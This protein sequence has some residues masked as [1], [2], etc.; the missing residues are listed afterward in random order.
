MI[1]LSSK[2]DSVSATLVRTSYLADVMSRRFLTVQNIKKYPLQNMGKIRT[3]IR[4]RNH[5]KIFIDN[6]KKAQ[7]TLYI[8]IFDNIKNLFAR[9]AQ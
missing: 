9:L 5:A 6:R 8:I 7:K 1:L 2:A 3:C 4:Y